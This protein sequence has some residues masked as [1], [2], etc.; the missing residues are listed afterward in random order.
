MLV[1]APR[2]GDGVRG[3]GPCAMRTGRHGRCRKVLGDSHD[4]RIPFRRRFSCCAVHAIARPDAVG[5]GYE[6]SP[7]GLPKRRGSPMPVVVGTNGGS[8]SKPV[9]AALWAYK[10]P[11]WFAR[12]L[13]VCRNRC[14]YPWCSATS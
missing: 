11:G 2:R 7:A 3:A 6:G 8:R 13:I 4:A 12:S 14:G 5:G 10:S 9:P 1:A